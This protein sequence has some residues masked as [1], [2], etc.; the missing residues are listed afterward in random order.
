MEKSTWPRVTGPL[1]EYAE[2]FGSEL[3]GLA[4]TPLTAASKVRQ[5]AHLSRWLAAKG[6]DASGLT[7]ESVAA[8]FAE[9][10][11]EGYV[12]DRTRRALVPLMTYLRR[13]DV[14]PPP[15]PTVPATPTELVLARFRD[16]LAVERGLAE[17]TT[18]LNVR[19]A[20]PFL[21][22]HA[23]GRDGDLDIATLTAAD[24]AAF[25]TEQAL[26]RP[27]SAQRMVSALRSL[28]GF[29]YLEQSIEMSL[30]PAVPP[31]A[32]WRLA[33]LPKALKDEQV[34]A[35]LAT[36]DLSRATGRR[37][38][39]ILT[40]LARLGL[41]AGEVAGLDLDDLDWR[42]G[43]I[44]VTGKANRSDR[45]PVPSDVGEKIVDYL[46]DSRPASSERAL[47][48]RAQAPYTRLSSGGVITVVVVAGRAAG[49]G[50][51]GA[52]RLRHSAATSILRAGG[53]LDEIGQLLRHRR[54]LTTAIYAKV[55]HLALRGL[56][57]PWPGEPR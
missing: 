23:A 6:L 42:R 52:H 35:L 5:M 4:Y 12:A 57:R 20:R 31:V 2:G 11:A 26:R 41:R 1:A 7:E 22:A 25:V 47:F 53:S 17:T 44:G 14:A 54:P 34:A 9:R 56:A 37:N 15:F 55:D 43:E 33:G 19:M 8:Y 40:L 3:L 16:Y 49:L 30:A 50:T 29:L 32:G 51:I 21:V 38:L 36:C 46:R 24:V 13:L 28:L 48:L 10:R 18:E 39:A 45:L 27:R